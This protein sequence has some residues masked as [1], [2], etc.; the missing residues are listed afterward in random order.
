M[1]SQT[2]AQFSKEVLSQLA[3]R[4]LRSDGLSSRKK[5]QGEGFSDDKSP[6]C[7]SFH[8]WE[9]RAAINE[10]SWIRSPPQSV[11]GVLPSSSPCRSLERMCVCVRVRLPYTHTH[12]QAL[13][14]SCGQSC[15]CGRNPP[16]SRERRSSPGPE[17]FLHPSSALA[18]ELP[19]RVRRGNA[20]V[21]HIFVHFSPTYK[22]RRFQEPW[23]PSDPRLL[24]AFNASK[25]NAP[26][27]QLL[28]LCRRVLKAVNGYRRAG[29]SAATQS[30]ANQEAV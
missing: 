4:K 13:G 9:A 8:L 26:P 28:P 2:I 21:P 7:F 22:L 25:V 30:H 24:A 12:T 6:S 27:Q 11:A 17:L 19:L 3:P 23:L 10:A 20:Q 18:L 1:G 16:T 15:S 14:S 29:N 5:E